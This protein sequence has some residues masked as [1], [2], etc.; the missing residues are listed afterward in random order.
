M[1]IYTHIY[2]SH[3]MCH[4]PCCRPVQRRVLCGPQHYSGPPATHRGMHGPH[5]AR[6]VDTCE[7]HTK[8][9]C[10]PTG[11]ASRQGIERRCYDAAAL[12]ASM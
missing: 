12:S 11:G 5:G 9:V 7:A 8:A 3:I 6:E 2:Y 4:R 1:F 10:K